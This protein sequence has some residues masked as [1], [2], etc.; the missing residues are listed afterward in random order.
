MEKLIE[1]L[2]IV[3]MVDENDDLIKISL[4]P[5]H[6]R[7]QLIQTD[8]CTDH[9]NNHIALGKKE[10][11]YNNSIWF[12]FYLYANFFFFFFAIK[13]RVYLKN[14]NCKCKKGRKMNHQLS[15]VNSF[16]IFFFFV[17]TLILL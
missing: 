5:L 11:L 14:E 2:N 1:D 8:Y 13:P 10:K 15:D 9:L 16:F 17:T 3:T 4:S 6:T 12:F 7:V